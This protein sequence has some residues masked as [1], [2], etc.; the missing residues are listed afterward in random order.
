LGS[1]FFMTEETNFTNLGLTPKILSI[2]EGLNFKVPTPIQTQA[3]PV[4]LAGKD[5][6]GIAQTGT[7]KT[8]AFGLP[9][10]QKLFFEQQNVSLV[11]LPTRELAIQVEDFFRKIGASSQI[12][13][14]LLIGG[15]NIK[16][17]IQ[18]LNRRP[19]I[20]IATPG[21]LID[22]LGQKTLRLDK[23]GILVLDEADRML[24]M[25]FAPQIKQVLLSVPKDR[26]TM[27]F[28]ATMPTDIV[29]LAND[30][31][32]LPVRVEV[33][34]AG[35][36]TKNV[37]HE[38]FFV[39]RQNKLLLLKNVLEE[40]TGSTLIFSRTK[41]GAKKIAAAI[42]DMG[43]T[44]VEIHSDRSL[45]QRLSA[46][47]GFKKGT[48]RIL[49]ATDIAA[50]G[51]D[52]SNIELVINYD[53][54]EQADDYVHRIGRTGRADKTGHAI[55]FATPDQKFDIRAI[56]RLINQQLP[57]SPLP[58]HLPPV[59]LAPD[60]KTKNQGRTKKSP[61]QN[62]QPKVFNKNRTNSA[63]P[64]SN[65]ENKYH[66][67]KPKLSANDR[68]AP[69]QNQDRFKQSK[70]SSAQPRIFSKNQTKPSKPW[71]SFDKQTKY[72]TN[73]SKPF[74]NYHSKSRQDQG[75]EYSKQPK[76][77]AKID[78]AKVWP[79]FDKKKKIYPKKTK[80]VFTDNLDFKSGKSQS[81]PFRKNEAQSSFKTKPSVKSRFKPKPIQSQNR[82]FKKTTSNSNFKKRRPTNS[83]KPKRAF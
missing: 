73:S 40:H 35:S 83:F 31:M 76:V 13:T 81:R 50:R 77:F 62:R 80:R 67:D 66:S 6:I 28:S 53:L 10:L 1:D 12:K 58:G 21:R 15:A 52:V 9:I 38:I 33:A 16:R 49:V 34:P 59:V 45:T 43:Q 5:L 72:H 61:S 24:D 37:S 75:Q 48:Y 51:L 63:K 56:E 54:P 23:V 14:A 65:F 70:S 8:L 22:H 68:P 78:S 57:V 27:L 39:H 4:A 26:Q 7:G 29:K 42:R 2:L 74:S 60:S 46:L 41:F 69:Q 47:N 17:Q 79:S 44:A 71:S 20:I 30:Y 55:S 32:R 11:I 82:P 64:W 18:Q 36:A 25:G 3:I 19:N